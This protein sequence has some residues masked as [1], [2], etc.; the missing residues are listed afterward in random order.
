MPSARVT[1]SPRGVWRPSEYRIRPAA[2][3]GLRLR[4]AEAGRRDERQAAHGRAV[5]D[6]AHGVRGGEGRRDDVHVG[7][8]VADER[9]DSREHDVGR[10]LEVGSIARAAAEQIGD[11]HRAL[12]PEVRHEV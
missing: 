12:R 10:V 9:V 2:L 7:A 6:R 11:A 5:R 8:R 3:A 4:A 1:M